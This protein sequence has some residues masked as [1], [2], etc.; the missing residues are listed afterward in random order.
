MTK[1]LTTRVISALVALGFLIAL[2]YF[3]ELQGLKIIVYFAVMVGAYELIRILL[4]KNTSAFHKALFYVFSVLVFH[5]AANFPNFTMNGLAVVLMLFLVLTILTHKSFSELGDLLN[6][7]AKS[8]F[9]FV[10]VGLLPASAY[11][12]IEL[13]NGLVWFLGLLGIVFAGDISAYAAGMLV[14]RHKILPRLSPKKTWEGSIGGLSGS[15][16]IGYMCS[17][18]LPHV[19]VVSLL[20][21]ALCA[22]F[23]AQAGDFFESLIKRVADVKDSG[24]LMPGHGGVL[25]RID[26]VLFASPIILAV[27]S[28]FEAI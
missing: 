9:S 12:L 14:G 17:H 19:P 7:Q 18:F 20:A 8:L 28:L 6:Y 23:A 5:L 24:S 4:P 27:A 21:T 22:G 2:Y 10:Y 11:R 16:L 13:P 26:G 15:L 1:T 25:D 3:F